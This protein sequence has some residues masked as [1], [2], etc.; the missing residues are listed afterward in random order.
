MNFQFYLEKLY[1]SE[2]YQKFIQENPKAYPCGAF[3]IVDNE[4]KESKQDFDFWL[5]DEKKMFSVKLSSGGE[6]IPVELIESDVPEKIRM[7]FDFDFNDIERMVRDKMD[8]EGIKNKLQKMLLSLQKKKG[9]DFLVGTV[10][11]SMMGM[12]KVA[13]DLESMKILDFE[14]KSFFDIMKVK[15]KD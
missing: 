2:H 12:I 3:F 9:K 11:I 14:K 7:N 5:P 10:F 15:K 6:I 8:E 1:A 13:I 4:G